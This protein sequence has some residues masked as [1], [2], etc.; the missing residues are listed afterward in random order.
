MRRSVFDLQLHRLRKRSLRGSLAHGVPSAGSYFKRPKNSPPAAYLIDQAGLKGTRI[1]DA[2]VSEKHAG[3]I[4]NVGNATA[5]DIQA[6]AE[7][8]KN[9]ILQAYGVELKEEVVLIK[10]TVR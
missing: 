4:V 7:Q 2:Q 5:K 1:G 6:L 3:F 10:E 8:I 9:K